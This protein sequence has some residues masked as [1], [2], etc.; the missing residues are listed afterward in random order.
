MNKLLVLLLAGFLI[1]FISKAQSFRFQANVDTVQQSG[2]HRIMLPPNVVGQ[3]NA[4]LTDIRLYDGQQKEVPYVLIRQQPEQVSSFADY[5]IVSKQSR[6]NVATTLVLRNQAKSRITSLSLVLKNTNVG[7]TAQLSGS[8]DAH[9][10]YAI[11]DAIWLGP[12]Q[13]PINTTETKQINF[14]LSDYEY[15]RLVINDSLST[16]LNIL[17]VGHSTQQAAAGAYSTIPNLSFSQRDSSDKHTYI[18]LV[19]SSNARF[20]KLIITIQASAPFSR[21]AEIGQF[22][23]RKLKRG[24][25]DRWFEVIRTI[26]LSSA[27]SHEVYLP[28]LKTKDVYVVIAN[29]DSPPLVIQDVHG[30]QLTTYLLADLLAGQPYQLH[31]STDD[32]VA[33]SYDLTPFK[34][35]STGNQPIIGIGPVRPNS[36]RSEQTTLFFTDSRIIWPALGLV[37]VVLGLLSYRMLR[38]MEKETV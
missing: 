4:S 9:N 5:D 1:T 7:K 36:I 6:P 13:N 33:P 8:S 24:R 10:W 25:I 20:D 32:V 22:H 27:D 12:T 34:P 18:H 35:I 3:L 15:Y 11:D 30:Y 21:R 38:A 31:F 17:R 19:G 28:G 26:E 14:P 2:F 16:P 29:D 37:L 23:S